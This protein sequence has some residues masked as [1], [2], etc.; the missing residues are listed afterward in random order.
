M[1]L[2]SQQTALLIYR[3]SILYLYL[4]DAYIVTHGLRLAREVESDTAD[5]SF[6]LVHILTVIHIYI[7]LY[8]YNYE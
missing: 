6:V 1:L 3:E 8:P 7:Y 5:K 2:N 4:I